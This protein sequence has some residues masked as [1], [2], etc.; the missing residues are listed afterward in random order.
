MNL[1]S[2]SVRREERDD[3][4]SRESCISHAFQDLVN[5]VGRL[6]YR[7]VRSGQCVVGAACH[8]PQTWATTAV[9]N[10]NRARKLNDVEFLLAV[11]PINRWGSVQVAE[12]HAVRED[13]H[14]L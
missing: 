7:Q 3:F 8:E 2:D 13:K 9:G 1:R 5:R 6:R 10:P 4:V 14:Q 12:G 11:V